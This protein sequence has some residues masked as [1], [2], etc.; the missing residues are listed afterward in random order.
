M[1]FVSE[2]PDVELQVSEV[3]KFE[4]VT[5]EKVNLFT[6]LLA[7]LIVPATYLFWSIFW[8][9]EAI[10][11][12]FRMQNWQFIG[13]MLLVFLFHESV[14]LIAHPQ[15]G[16]SDKSLAGASLKKMYFF[17]A[18]KDALSRNRLI[19]VALFPFFV[20]SAFPLVLSYFFPSYV[21]EL[22][23]CSIF[24]AGSSG[25]DIYLAIVIL[26]QVPKNYYIHGQ[27]YGNL[28]RK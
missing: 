17:V 19:F 24:N 7:F 11:G 22:A 1:K 26:K 6:L 13:S 4:L 27:H 14:H 21:S 8:N 12:I 16:F 28:L 9:N 20:L 15:F 3:G 5:S 25:V 18:Y 2:V 23:W 10:W